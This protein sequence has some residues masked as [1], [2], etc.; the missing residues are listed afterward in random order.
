MVVKGRN[1]AFYASSLPLIGRDSCDG[2][3]KSNWLCYCRSE[4]IGYK[5]GWP[6]VLRTSRSPS[7]YIKELLLE[8]EVVLCVVVGDI[9]DHLMDERHL[10]SRQFAVSDIAS[11]SIAQKPAEILVTRI[12]DETA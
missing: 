8:V 1:V 4:A 6:Q 5:K 3:R 7:S 2:N 11:E 9:L 10:G 12:A